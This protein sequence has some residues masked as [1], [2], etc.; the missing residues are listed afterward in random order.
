MRGHSRV[1][2]NFERETEIDSEG[3][4]IL[5]YGDMVTL[6]LM[7]FILYFSVDPQTD[8]MKAIQAVLL[9][10]LAP[11]DSSATGQPYNFSLGKGKGE[12]LSETLISKWGAQVGTIGDK[13]FVEFPEVSFFAFGGVKVQSEGV[14]KLREFVKYYTPFAGD[15]LLT[16]RAFTD[17]VP[18]YAN[19]SSLFK[20]NLELSALRSIAALRHLQKAGIPLRRM[21]AEGY[22]E[23]KLSEEDKLKSLESAK[24]LKQKGIPL[25]R[26]LVLI[27][28]PEL[29]DKL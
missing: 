15:Y 13:I 5:S 12:A 16:I 29:R 20:D 3:S 11:K 17:T 8:R 23:L 26:R 14:K 6:L 9:D 2:K 22:G 4:W 27:I 18:V 7:F 19:G 24:K 1:R 21:R 25:A 28:E 10:Q